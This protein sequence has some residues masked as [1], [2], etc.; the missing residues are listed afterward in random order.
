MAK[1][2]VKITEIL[3]GEYEFEAESLEH[4]KF[5]LQEGH[6]AHGKPVNG[7]LQTESLV[8]HVEDVNKFFTL[9]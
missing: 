9:I 3:E 1:F 7:G 2:I 6:E 5:L 4:L 8:A